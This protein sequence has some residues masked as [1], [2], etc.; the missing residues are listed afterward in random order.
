[1]IYYLNINDLNEEAQ[2]RLIEDA[3]ADLEERDGIE[4]LQ[5]EAKEMNIDYDVFIR[6]MA[7]R[8]IYN[9]NFVFN[10]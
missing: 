4:E 5:Q 7:E 6:E 3:I 8:H 9:F 2:Q 10:V 1:M